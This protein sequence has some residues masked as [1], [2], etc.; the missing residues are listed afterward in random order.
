MNKDPNRS[1]LLVRHKILS[2]NM[3]GIKCVRKA[4]PNPVPKPINTELYLSAI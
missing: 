1:L 2:I 4:I 3:F